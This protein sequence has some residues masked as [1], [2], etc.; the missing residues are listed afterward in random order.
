MQNDTAKHSKRQSASKWVKILAIHSN[1]VMD[2]IARKA[3]VQRTGTIKNKSLQLLAYADD[4]D[5]ISHGKKATA[6]LGRI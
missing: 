1:F 3:G 2:S 4:I 6:P 5:I